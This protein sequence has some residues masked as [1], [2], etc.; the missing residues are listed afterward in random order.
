MISL[1]SIVQKYMKNL[2]LEQGFEVVLMSGSG[3]SFFCLG[4][5]E[6]PQLPGV[7]VF[8]AHTINRSLEKWYS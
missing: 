2:L 5:G 4:Q 7:T 8:P 1:S 3:S 6:V